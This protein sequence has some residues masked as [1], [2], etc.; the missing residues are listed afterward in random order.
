VNRKNAKA[1]KEGGVTLQLKRTIKTETTVSIYGCHISLIHAL[2]QRRCG[3]C[4]QMGHMSV[5]VS[6]SSARF[7]PSRIETNRNCPKWAEYNTPQPV[8]AVGVVPSP[9]ANSPPAPGGALSPPATGSSQGLGYMSASDGLFPSAYRPPSSAYGFPAAV[10]SPLATS[11]PV[12]AAA[13]DGFDNESQPP[14]PPVVAPHAG[15]L[16]PPKIKLKLGKKA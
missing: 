14:Q 11:P 13:F 3:H 8:G 9:S 1:V 4:G 15:V 16:A 2:A 6:S 12:S 7:S 10:P 5:Y